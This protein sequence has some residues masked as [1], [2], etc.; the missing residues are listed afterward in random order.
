MN[1]FY[2]WKNYTK[3]RILAIIFIVHVTYSLNVNIY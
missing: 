1:Y 3:N 2:K